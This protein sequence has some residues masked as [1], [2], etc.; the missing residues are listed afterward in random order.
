MKSFPAKFK[1]FQQIIVQ[2]GAMQK[3][4]NSIQVLIILQ[5][6]YQVHTNSL[7]EVIF[8]ELPFCHFPPLNTMSSILG[9]DSNLVNLLFEYHI[10]FKQTENIILFPSPLAFLQLPI[11]VNT[12]AVITFENQFPCLWEILAQFYS[13]SRYTSMKLQLFVVFNSHA[14]FFQAVSTHL[15]EDA[16]NIL[17]SLARFVLI[18]VL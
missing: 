11:K 14:F 9:K 7:F 8:E 6:V 18:M 5:L 10:F 12:T 13:V 17:L 2:M 3:L 1:S 15:T 4:Q 16:L